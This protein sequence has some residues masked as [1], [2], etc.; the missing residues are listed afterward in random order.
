VT[1]TEDVLPWRKRQT[2][3]TAGFVS[4]AVRRLAAERGVDVATLTGSGANGRITRADVEAPPA[5]ARGDEVVP[6]NNI[7]KRAA[8]MLLASKQTSPHTLCTVRANYSSIEAA[9]AGYRLTYLPFVARAVCDALRQFPHMNAAVDGETLVV[10]R[11]INLGIAVDLDFQG[12]IVPVVRDADGLRLH[13]L[14]D[15]IRDVATR[16]RNKKLVPD[17]LAGGSFTITNPGGYGT[18][19]SFP[20]INQ[21]Q[22]G[23]LATDGVSK[24]VYVDDAGRMDIAPMGHLCLTFDHRAVDGAYAGSFLARVKEIVET[25]DWSTE[26]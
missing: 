19:Q 7:R 3:E 11:D 10:R 4:P 9:R 15:A 6:F 22:V 24:Q 25:R 18:W 8:G 2:R 26:L 16:A 12:L 13:A 5:A 17:D 1:N 20:I 21:P 14:A 23:I